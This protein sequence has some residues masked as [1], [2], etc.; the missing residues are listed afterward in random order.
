MGFYY[1]KNREPVTSKR[2]CVERD[3]RHHQTRDSDRY[4]R[5]RKEEAEA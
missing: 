2:C 5:E 4:A 1:D 3:K